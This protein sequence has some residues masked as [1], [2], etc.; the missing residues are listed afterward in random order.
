VIDGLPAGGGNL[1]LTFLAESTRIRCVVGGPEYWADSKNTNA[2]ARRAGTAEPIKKGKTMETPHFNCDTH[3]SES[4]V[5]AV[6]TNEARTLHRL[7]EVRVQQGISIRV[8]SK[9]L[10]LTTQ[11]L[12]RQLSPYSDLPLSQLYKWQAALDVPLAELLVAPRSSLSPAV[13][14]RARLVK[15][16]KSVRSLQRLADT[17]EMRILAERLADQ[18]IGIMPELVDVDSWPAVGPRRSS[19]DVSGL[20]LRSVPESVFDRS[21]LPMADGD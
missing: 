12:D 13:D 15:L 17:D 5:P 16:M 9:R 8:L 4:P 21:R 19:D 1:F 7:A 2:P 10:G 18:L 14:R 11:E 6:P 20:E 3:V